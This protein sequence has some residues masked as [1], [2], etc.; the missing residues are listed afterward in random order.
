MAR[1]DWL[2][3]KFEVSSIENLQT[4]NFTSSE[5]NDKISCIEF[6]VNSQ[7]TWLKNPQRVTR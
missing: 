4:F 3:S 5:I 7:E 6:A 2:K 1:L